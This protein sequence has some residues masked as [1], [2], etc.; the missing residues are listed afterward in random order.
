MQH[1][2]L[3]CHLVLPL[4]LD[5]H[6]QT[7]SYTIFK[8]AKLVPLISSGNG[9][10]SSDVSK[11]SSLKTGGK[12]CRTNQRRT[13]ISKFQVSIYALLRHRIKTIVNIYFTKSINFTVDTVLG[14]YKASVVPL[15]SGWE[16]NKLSFHFFQKFHL[17]PI[18]TG[19]NKLRSIYWQ[20]T[21]AISELKNVLLSHTTPSYKIVPPN[22]M[23]SWW[24]QTSVD[25][26]GCP[27]CVRPLLARLLAKP[28]SLVHYHFRSVS[29]IQ[30]QVFEA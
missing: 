22:D 7:A 6:F 26:V 4:S 28:R 23:Q 12:S 18:C 10:S 30:S 8:P 2:L 14:Q 3:A 16:P 19:S 11:I 27:F 15:S 25:A 5:S 9:L 13:N 17:K 29:E 20:K 1:I 21:S 24:S